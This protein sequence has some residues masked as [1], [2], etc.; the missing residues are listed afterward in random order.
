M[1]S[2]PHDRKTPFWTAYLPFLNL[3][4]ILFNEVRFFISNSSIHYT[5]KS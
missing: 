1:I 5:C 2:N 3:M 4:I